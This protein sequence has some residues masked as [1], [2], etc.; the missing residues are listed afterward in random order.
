MYLL[1]LTKLGQ[2]LG[3][4]IETIF[5]SVK[6]TGGNLYL[7]PCLNLVFQDF[8][9]KKYE[10]LSTWAKQLVIYIADYDFRILN[11]C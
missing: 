4:W 11:N 2:A 8:L 1:W 10:D 3:E 6:I 5:T 7:F 9:W